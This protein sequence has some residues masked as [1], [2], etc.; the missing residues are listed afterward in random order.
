MMIRVLLREYSPGVWRLRVEAWGTWE[1]EPFIA[2]E[3]SITL[4][5]QLTHWLDSAR[6][7]STR[8][9]SIRRPYCLSSQQ[10]DSL[11]WEFRYS[12]AVRVATLLTPLRP[13]LRSRNDLSLLA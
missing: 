11:K 10:R 5:P 9:P 7:V 12:S 2:G 13:L 3:A 6:T 1:H 4:S 8:A